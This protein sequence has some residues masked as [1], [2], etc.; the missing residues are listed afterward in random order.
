MRT[1]LPSP[2]RWILGAAVLSLM[3]L[4]DGVLVLMFAAFFL[5]GMAL[6]A[7]LRT[8]DAGPIYLLIL[9]GLCSAALCAVRLWPMM[10]LLQTTPRIVDDRDFLTLRMA[11]DALF[12]FDQHDLYLNYRAVSPH[13]VWGA[14][15]AFSGVL[16]WVLGAYGVVRSR[17]PWR[18]PLLIVMLFGLVLMFGNF[19]GLAPWTLLR[20]IPP[21]HMVRAPYRFVILIL[22]GLAILSMVG[23]S[24]LFRDLQSFLTDRIGIPKAR[25]AASVAVAVLLLGTAANLRSALAP[26]LNDMIVARPAVPKSI[27]GRDQRFG[28]GIGNPRDMLPMIAGNR[29]ILNCYRSMPFDLIVDPSTPPA[30]LLGTHQEVDIFV[31]VN[32]LRLEVE[33]AEPGFV[34]VNQRYHRDWVV[35]SGTVEYLG[36]VGPGLIG[37]RLPAGE[38]VVVLSFASGSFIMGLFLTSF[39]LLCALVA[40]LMWIRKRNFDQRLADLATNPARDA[41]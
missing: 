24:A 13:S 31:G 41:D 32:E 18:L 3:I 6:V 15:G 26:L 17:G 30:Y 10:E 7:S 28:H 2:H 34:L 12:H 29:G 40:M 38:Q 14:Y 8:R 21:F 20:G 19:A 5:G 23:G 4:E 35:T 9:W 37:L 27:E 25:T 36:P 1:G 39:S 33:L 11:Y 16:P 22:M